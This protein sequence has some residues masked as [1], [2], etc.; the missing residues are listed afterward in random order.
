[1]LI[2]L[3]RGSTS[4][5]LGASSTSQDCVNA[6]PRSDWFDAGFGRVTACSTWG[7]GRV[8]VRRCRRRWSAPST[9]SVP[10]SPCCCGTLSSSLW[11]SLCS[12]A[13]CVFVAR[14]ATVV[15]TPTLS[16]TVLPQFLII[17]RTFVRRESWG[18]TPC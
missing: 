18:S 11:N 12:D 13:V 10:M 9:V 16:L 2:K 17:V 7:L 3:S 14:R 1:M 4:E 6:G 5:E 15:G 8:A